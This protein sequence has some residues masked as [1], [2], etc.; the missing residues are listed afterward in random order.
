MSR[1]F[2]LSNIVTKPR[3]A[4]SDGQGLIVWARTLTGWIDRHL[5]AAGS[6]NDD[7]SAKGDGSGG[8]GELSLRVH[9][10]AV[11]K[12]LRARRAN[13]RWRWRR[14]RSPSRGLVSQP[15]RA[16]DTAAPAAA[17]L[18]GATSGTHRD[19]YRR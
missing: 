19:A 4:T 11:L 10:V 6:A 18:D 16:P 15:R 9:W 3:M 8:G 17:F 1:L 12:M 14:R 2:L 5:G 7:D 13:R